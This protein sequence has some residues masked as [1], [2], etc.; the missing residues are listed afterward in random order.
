[1]GL[2]S[3]AWIAAHLQIAFPLLFTDQAPV[4]V[5]T[6]FYA[7]LKGPYECDSLLLSGI[8]GI[9]CWPFGLALQSILAR[10][11]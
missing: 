8:I 5:S 2:F 3:A 6:T 4:A 11:V 7:L 1:V 9:I 10:A